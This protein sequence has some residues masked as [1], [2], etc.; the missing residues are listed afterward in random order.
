M[1]VMQMLG[2][3]ATLAVFGVSIVFSFLLILIVSITLVSKIIR[4]T[5]ADE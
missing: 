4:N 1:T 5:E 3:S 2:Q